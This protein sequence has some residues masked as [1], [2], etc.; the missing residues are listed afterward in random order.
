MDQGELAQLAEPLFGGIAGGKT[1]EPP[2]RYTG[3][4]FRTAATTAESDA[5]LA[6][7]V[8]PLGFRLGPPR[9][10]ICSKVLPPRSGAF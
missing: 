1:K 10:K 2:S 5:L 3:G 7:E 6:F 8:R 9:R 4:D